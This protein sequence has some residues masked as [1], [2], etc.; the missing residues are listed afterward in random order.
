MRARDLATFVAR[1]LLLC[2][3]FS[4]TITTAG[5]KKDAQVHSL[6]FSK[7]VPSQLNYQG[8]LVDA[9]DSSAVTA[10]LEM[11]FRLFDSET[12]GAELWSETHPAVEINGGL[13]QVLLGSVTSFP[14]GL[15]GGAPLWLQTEVDTEVLAPRKPLV[16]VAYSQRSETAAQASTANW[17]TEA[18]HAIYADTADYTLSAGVW[19]VDGDNVYRETG[20]VGIGTS[21]PLTEL[22]V[23]GSVNATTYYGDGSHLTGI[24]GTPDGDWTISGSDLYSAVSGKVGIGTTVP[25]EKLNVV[26]SSGNYSII[27]GSSYGVYGRHVSGEKYGYLASSSYGVYGGDFDSGNYGY[28]GGSNYGAY[29][30]S[31]QPPK[32]VLGLPISYDGI[33]G[34]GS[35]PA[36]TGVYGHHVDTGN[37]G[38]LAGLSQAVYGVH[39]LSG[40]YGHIG[41]GNFG[42]YGVHG[43]AVGG[44]SSA[45]VVGSSVS[46][47]GVRGYSTNNS[48]IV[49]YSA[50]STVPAIAGYHSGDGPAIYGGCSGA[51]PCVEGLRSDD[52]IAVAGYS[53]TGY[54][55]LGHAGSTDGMG[56]VGV[57]TDHFWSDIS[58]YGNYTPGGLFGGRNGIIGYTKTYNGYAVM[59][60]SISSN[61]SSWAGYFVSAGSGVYIYAPSGYTGLTVAGGTKNALVRTDDGGRLLYCEESTEVWFSDHGFGQLQSGSTRVDIDP[62]FAQ[63]VT[64]DEPYHVFIQV[65]GDADVYVANRTSDHFEVRLRDGDPNVEFSYRIM[66]KRA[67]YEGTRLE[68]PAWAENDPNLYPERQF[69]QQTVE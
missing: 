14:V 11:T 64:L 22:D 45:G 49:G 40:N 27:A 15:F 33:R 52:G 36:A 10:T 9:T 68:R 50:G 66:A 1:T 63:T 4:A 46:D 13:F 34:E 59:G 18:Q 44:E 41:S 62:L 6:D 30:Y 2:V 58:M 47:A 69:E 57:Q 60:R 20:K 48:G 12:K 35:G 19:T 56:V 32:S 5:T 21:S 43:T 7:A 54:G 61:T 42:V 24:S 25:A 16:S 37:F 51:Y 53:D 23:T 67:G 8:Y 17:A 39:S 65:Y 3:L 26:G 29:G 38:Y 31:E 28:L 55:V